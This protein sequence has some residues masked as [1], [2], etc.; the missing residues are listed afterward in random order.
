MSLLD[1]IA[2]FDLTQAGLFCLLQHA[3]T[4]NKSAHP[5]GWAENGFSHAV[6][7]PTKTL[8]TKTLRL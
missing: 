2:L 3:L 4:P 6:S 5:N 1:N 7:K 8:P